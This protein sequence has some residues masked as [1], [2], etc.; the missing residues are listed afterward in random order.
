MISVCLASYNGEKYIKEQLDSILSQL[1][2]EDELI[3]S[4]DCSIDSTPE[5]LSSFAEQYPILRIVKGPG[6][7]VIKNFEYA[8]S[9]SKG[10][11]LFLSDQDD[12]WCSSKVSRVKEAFSSSGE[13][14][15][16]VL[17]DAEIVDEDAQRTGQTLFEFRNS[18]QG[19]LRCLWKNPYVGC[20]MA[21][22]KELTSEIFPFPEG[23]EMH[24][25]WI[26]LNA[27][28]GGR[29]M[30]I[31]DKLIQYRRHTG[32]VSN[33]HHHPL[34]KMIHN[35]ILFIRVLALHRL[36]IKGKFHIR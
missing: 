4:D 3:V 29:T 27:E 13:N 1:S 16:L 17:H 33:M 5:I 20:C 31:T 26:A 32:N 36:A 7:G 18:R 8:I 23:I 25:W 12:I 10:E 11:L 2:D 24:D 35:R 28:C 21:I 6:K 30:L 19:L 22:R 15:M 34:Y 14:C 9:L